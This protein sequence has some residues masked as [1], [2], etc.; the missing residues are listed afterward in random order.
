MQNFIRM[1]RLSNVVGRV[2]YA[3]NV[4]HQH[5]DDDILC[6]GGPVQDLATWSEYALYEQNH[7]RT[8]EKNNEGRELIVALPNEWSGRD[9]SDLADAVDILTQK[10]IGKKTDYVFAVH[11]NENHTNLHAHIIFS[12]RIRG[13][14]EK[15]ER[16]DR[17]IYLTAKGTVARKKSDR[18]KDENG[19]EL[20]PIHRKGE[21]KNPTGITFTS[22]NNDYSTRQWLETVKRI[23]HK[24][25]ECDERRPLPERHE[26]S[27][28]YTNQFIRED[29][30]KYN[31]IIQQINSRL[32]SQE[33]EINRID[34][35]FISRSSRRNIVKALNAVIAADTSAEDKVNTVDADWIYEHLTQ[36]DKRI[37]DTLQDICDWS[38]NV[39]KALDKLNQRQ[40]RQGYSH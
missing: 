9:R 14:S 10:L 19:A 21:L 6:I 17:D 28:K 33:H 3:T 36:S 25:L 2:E 15:E 13:L 11:W 34:N 31:D 16:W 5:A 22:K 23:A 32:I 29:N 26:G 39:L 8:T 30:C 38:D 20:P 40:E 4:T 12:E 37:T 35:M 7:Q 27:L 1:T 24:E 18:A